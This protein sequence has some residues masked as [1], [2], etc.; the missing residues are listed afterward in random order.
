MRAPIPIFADDAKADSHRH[1][2]GL[3]RLVN[4]ICYRAILYAATSDIAII[5]ASKVVT[6]SLFD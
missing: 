4:A 6:D 3:P 1:T 2:G 5:D